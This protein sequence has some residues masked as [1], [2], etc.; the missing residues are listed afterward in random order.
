M[1]KKFVKSK[2]HRALIDLVNTINRPQLD[3]LLL[4]NAGV[5]LDQALFP[6][7]VRV[8]IYEP[9]GVSKLAQQVGRDHSTVSRQVAK[10]EGLGLIRRVASAADQRVR[11]ASITP[12]GKQMVE[13]IGVAR[14]QLFDQMLKGWKTEERTELADLIRRLADAYMSAVERFERK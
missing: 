5:M 8:G 2:L 4:R 14:D 6:L 7:L 1:N 3:K 12:S 13:R 11:E 10:L 9:I